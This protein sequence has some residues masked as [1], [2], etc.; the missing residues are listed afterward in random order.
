MPICPGS[1]RRSGGG[2]TFALVP[3]TLCLG[4]APDEVFYFLV[5]PESAESISIDIGYC[6]DRRR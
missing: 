6:F 5:D 4:F 2:S 3:P 1:L